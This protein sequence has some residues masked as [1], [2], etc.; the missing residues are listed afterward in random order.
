MLFFLRKLIEALLLPLG[1]TVF[2]VLIAVFLRRRW[3]ALVA[4]VLLY[5]F[6]I[7]PVANLLLRP[8]ESTY[9][10]VA[11]AAAPHADA[12]V[13]L[14]GG[15][16]RGRNRVGIQWS[17]DANRFF[18]AL[19]L[20]RAGKANLLV[21]SAGLFPIDGQILRQAAIDAG[22]SAGHIVL[23]DQVFTTEDEARAVS[24]I[25]GIHSILLVTSAFH[26]PRAAL[27]FR[28]R[29]FDI[30]PF[31]TDQRIFRRA[32]LPPAAFIPIPSALDNSESALREYYGLL[33]YRTL[34]FLHIH[35]TL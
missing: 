3:L 24:R 5:A 4:A 28:S 35:H 14:S 17:R 2:L 32:T 6:S 19:D 11:V 21:I 26:M 29:G 30:F 31:P 8:L 9:P 16:L 10:P 20:A 22:V 1:F 13:I 34:L 12:I 23:T 18:T 7:P 15:I 27:L 33:V 25:P